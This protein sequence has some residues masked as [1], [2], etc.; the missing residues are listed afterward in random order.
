MRIHC[1][2]HVSHEGPG[3]ITEWASLHGDPISFTYLF[4]PEYRFPEMEDFDFL[5]VMGGFMNVDEESR[6]AWLRAE[7]DFILRAF[8]Q[9]KKI[10]G[11]CLGSQL[12]AAA[13]GSRVYKSNEKEI[14][15]YPLH[16]NTNA[17]AHPLFNHF[18]E[19]YP[20]FHWHGDSFELPGDSI[21]MASTA[22]C[23]NQAFLVEVESSIGTKEKEEKQY[24]AIGLQ[25]H[26]EMNEESL[27]AMVTADKKE[28][29]EGGRKVQ[30]EE[31]IRK[32]YK[33]L[34]QNRQDLFVLLDKF[35]GL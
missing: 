16:F 34:S 3:T 35:I 27:E 19:T 31:E 18:S 20:V 33:W 21:L 7:K 32:G 6:F 29:E 1:L 26:L 14:G 23:L 12:L 8:E 24:R 4:D 9:E 17:L 15:F 5:L 22:G 28:L 13:L 11:I 2:Q 25:F 10:L 30:G